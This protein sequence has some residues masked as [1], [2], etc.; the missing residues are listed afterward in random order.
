MHDTPHKK[1]NG[2]T[3]RFRVTVSFRNDEEVCQCAFEQAVRIVFSHLHH[4]PSKRL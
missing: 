3:D 4:D 1:S 2:K